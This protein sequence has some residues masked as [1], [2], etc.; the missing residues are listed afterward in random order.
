MG[1]MDLIRRAEEQSR[2]AARRGRDVARA[3]WN[4][5]GR[6]LRRKMRVNSPSG[7]V[8]VQPPAVPAIA[9]SGPP[10]QAA[11]SPR[12]KIVSING[13]DVRVEEQPAPH[14]RRSA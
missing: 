5:T 6:K 11:A 10:S 12:K 7:K 1:L 4:E 2:T 14:G 3:T 9:N 8:A 13:Q